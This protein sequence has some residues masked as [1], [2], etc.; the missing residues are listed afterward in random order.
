MCFS[1]LP[2]EFDDDGNPRLV[3]A[4]GDDGNQTHD[5]D[6]PVAERATTDDGL[7]PETRYEAILDGL[8]DRTRDRLEDSVD[9]HHA[10]PHTIAE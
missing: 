7:D 4:D 8:P 2:V 3:D 1:N 9:D 5:H 6:P 10:N